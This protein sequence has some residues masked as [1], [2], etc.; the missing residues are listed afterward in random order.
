MY[1]IDLF[2]GMGG[3]SLGL[4]QAG[5]NVLG[6]D[7]W[8]HAVN[9]HNA[10]G[11]PALMK[12]ISVDTDWN[13]VFGN[14]GDADLLWASPPCQ[15]FSQANSHGSGHEDSRNGFPAAIGAI[16]ALRPRVVVFENVKGITS[17][18]NISTFMSYMNDIKSLGYSVSWQ[19]LNAAAYGVPQSRKRCFL[20]ARNDQDPKFP[21]M[22]DKIVTMAEGLGRNNLPKW[23]MEKPST[24]IV[25]S[26]K[27]EMV[28]P[29]TWRKA[30][31][32]PRQNQPDAVEISLQEAL[33]LQSFPKD[34]KVCGPKTAQWLQ[35]GNAVPPKI[36]RLLAECNM[37]GV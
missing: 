4:K 23:A 21:A 34:Y 31:D 5:Y 6:V 10:N 32:G 9:T 13:N 26:F 15:S 19:I 2:C 37:K 8:K 22:S 16:K 18:N 14:Y 1:A 28:A 33:V 17:A 27:P 35:V 24:T 12:K 36:A 7:F 11:M 3:A 25:G 30:G 20:V 29:P